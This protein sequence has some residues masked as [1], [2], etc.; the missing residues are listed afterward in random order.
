MFYKNLLHIQTHH[1]NEVLW[2]LV[3]FTIFGLSLMVWL[4]LN[5]RA[6]RY[7][8]P[9]NFTGLSLCALHGPCFELYYSCFDVLC[10]TKSQHVLQ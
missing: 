7:A 5:G 10:K 3:F 2:L 6:R 9:L 4:K 8:P 1:C